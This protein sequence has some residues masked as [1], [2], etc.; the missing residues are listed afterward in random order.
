[1]SKFSLWN[2]HGLKRELDAWIHLAFDHGLSQFTSFYSIKN[3]CPNLYK[4]QTI[5]SLFT[6]AS[7]TSFTQQYLKL[8]R[9]QVLLSEEANIGHLRAKQN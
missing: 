2:G 7:I 4:Q 1:M 6:F 8:S 3:I 5:V 9:Y